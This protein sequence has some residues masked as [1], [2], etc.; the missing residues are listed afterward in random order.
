MTLVELIISIAIFGM[1]TAV[2][3]AV[4]VAVIR[5]P[6]SA[7]AR[8]DDA[9]S[10]LGLTTWLPGDVNS[11]RRVPTASASPDWWN[12]DPSAP[13]GCTS[14]P[15]GTNLVR[16]RWSETD[17]ATQ[18]FEANYRLVEGRGWRIVRVSCVVGQVAEVRNMTAKLPAPSTD[19]V[20]VTFL[21]DAVAG[22]T[23]GIRMEVTTLAGDVLTIEAT[24]DSPNQV[25]PTVPVGA[26]TTAA[27]TTT[28][29]TTTT[30]STTLAPDPSTT[31]TSTTSTTSTST[32][33]TSTTTTTV[34]CTAS[35]VSVAPSPVA[36]QPLSNGNN[37]KESQLTVPVTVTVTKS[38]GCSGLTLVY[39]RKAGFPYPPGQEIDTL[40]GASSTITFQVLST[41]RWED[42]AHLLRLYDALTSTFVPSTNSFVV[43]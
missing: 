10:L 14:S 30:T 19:P 18:L 20:T 27:P 25:L 22:E 42:G 31:T 15:T 39:S 26:T 5:T 24:S 23:I 43:T 11:T 7:E 21:T 17:G 16:L 40:F 4:F 37:D 38:G 34:P 2:L 36:N 3:L 6:P 28:T 41:E 35:F 1:I 13:S 8:V 29:T 33:S 32:T 9:R 12:I